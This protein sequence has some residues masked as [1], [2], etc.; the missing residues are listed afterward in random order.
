MQ[1]LIIEDDEIT[2]GALSAGFAQKNESTTVCSRGNEGL[3][4][5]LEG[6][7]DLA[8]IDIW[9]PEISG[10]DIIRTAKERG[11]KTPIIVLTG[12]TD[13]DLRKR[14]AELGVK[15]FME[16]PFSF[17]ELYAHIETL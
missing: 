1:I 3:R 8:I 2:S 14:L 6:E 12:D 9:L 10:E 15:H 4:E 13:K 7:Y 17:K 11:V 16:K 5:L